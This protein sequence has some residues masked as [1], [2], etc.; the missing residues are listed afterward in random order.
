MKHIYKFLITT[1]LILLSSSP[2]H[3]QCPYNS[4]HEDES[5]MQQLFN[6]HNNERNSVNTVRTIVN[7][8]YNFRYN[9][10]SN[11]RAIG[12]WWGEGQGTRILTPSMHTFLE[13]L[14]PGYINTAWHEAFVG[15]YS[16]YTEWDS[17]YE[18]IPY[19]NEYG[20]NILGAI[21]DITISGQPAITFTYTNYR[22]DGLGIKTYLIQIP[23]SIEYMEISASSDKTEALDTI[24]N[25]FVFY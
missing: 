18:V 2:A 9:I 7:S 22:E 12:I 15:V 23:N 21:E 24:I 10:P 1:G 5:L 25:S 16:S 4:F 3:S 11:Y 19:I 17:L 13:C 8:R 20:V 6:S 14:N